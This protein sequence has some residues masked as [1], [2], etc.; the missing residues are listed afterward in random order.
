M[1]YFSSLYYRCYG[2]IGSITRTLCS[3]DKI[4]TIITDIYQEVLFKK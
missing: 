1:K 4:F 2:H 3:E